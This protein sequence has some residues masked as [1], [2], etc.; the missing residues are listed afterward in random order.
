MV[1]IYLLLLKTQAFTNAGARQY[2]Q[3][4]AQD[5]PPSAQAAK[6]TTGLERS[7]GGSKTPPSP[8]V[9]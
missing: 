9:E 3:E 8:V 4:Y 7:R 5:P 1:G 6:Y 2:A